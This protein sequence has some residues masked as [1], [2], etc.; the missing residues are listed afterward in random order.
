MAIE[1][2]SHLKPLILHLEYSYLRARAKEDVVTHN[3]KAI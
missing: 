3:F 1:R 2:L